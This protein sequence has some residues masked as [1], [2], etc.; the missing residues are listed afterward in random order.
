MSY[1]FYP[2]T[3]AIPH[4]V[5]TVHNTPGS[6]QS[7]PVFRKLLKVLQ[8]QGICSD[9]V[10]RFSGKPPFSAISLLKFPAGFVLSI[11]RFIAVVW[12]WHVL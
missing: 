7:G 11:F 8:G 2:N 5:S 9:Y 4:R 1:P 6:R 10:G 12:N 3:D